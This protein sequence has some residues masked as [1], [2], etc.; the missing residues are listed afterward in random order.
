MYVVMKNKHNK[1]LHVS[2]GKV[3]RILTITYKVIESTVDTTC[4][5]CSVR[6]EEIAEVREIVGLT[7]RQLAKRCSWPWS[8][9]KRFEK[10]GLNKVPLYHVLKMIRTLSPGK[11]IGEQVCRRQN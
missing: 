10:P 7:F 2:N 3:V 5:L 11:T 4:P 8:H 6:G 9:Q 1:V